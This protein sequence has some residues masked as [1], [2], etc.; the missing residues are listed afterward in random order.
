MKLIN[1]KTIFLLSFVF[2]VAL[3]AF[4]FGMVSG[5]ENWPPT[6]ISNE[7][8]DAAKSLFRTGQALPDSAY[9]KR[10]WYTPEQRYLINNPDQIMAGFL[11][12]S[13]MDGVAARYVVDLLDANGEVL[14]SWPIDY[15]K[16]VENEE[17]LQ[18]TH[19]TKVMRDGSLLV[20]FDRGHAMARLDQC[21]V[22]MWAKTDQTYH[23]TFQSDLNGIWTWRALLADSGVDQ[24]LYRF[25]PETGDGLE[26]IDLIDDVV[27]ASPNNAL[28]TAIPEGYKFTRNIRTNN[29][30]DLFHPNDIE[31]LPASMADAFPQFSTGDLLISLKSISLVAVLD[32]VTHEFLWAS[33]GPWHHQHDPDWQP[34]GTITI[35]NNNMDRG[36]SNIVKIDPKTGAASVLFPDIAP[37]FYSAVMGN[38]QRLPNGNWLILSSMEGRV[39]EVTDT[40]ET[41]REYSNIINDKYNAAVPNVEF[42]P[43]DYFDE[44]PK[45]DLK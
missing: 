10:R 12:V 36:R 43:L 37:M 9:F 31:P 22:T 14:H 17:P 23:H 35:F 11:A 13:R 33:S 21:G 15:S 30:I 45:C 20:S 29:M 4:G 42:L 7:I 39:I 18:F 26:S 40:G 5:K 41:V 27:T 3:T 19:A 2:L 24:K 28:L 38:H 32:R 34:D 25:D 1:E 8:F 16:L 44:M 6:K